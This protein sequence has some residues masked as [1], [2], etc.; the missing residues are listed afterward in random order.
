[1]FYSRGV[2]IM[3]VKD[4]YYLDAVAFGDDYLAHHGIKGQ[5]WGVRRYQN[6]DGSLTE[7]GKKRYMSMND[8]KLYKTLKKEI[9]QRRGAMYGS[10][11][12]WMY[13]NEIGEHSK[14][15]RED[16]RKN[17]KAYQ[18]TEQYK[19]ANRAFEIADRKNVSLVES[20]KISIEEYQHRL[21]Q[22][23]RD[24]KKSLP[25]KNYTN[26]DFAKMYTGHGIKYVDDFVNKG[27][28]ELS[29]ARLRDLGYSTKVADDFVKRMARSGYTLG[30]I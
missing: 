29:V 16:F 17:K 27:G 14:K 6:E 30:D 9:R 13:D 11:N 23:T 26:L 28:A 3:E 21:D 4:I 8:K 20:G 7:A 10:A 18:N 5:K 2:K 1:M 12:R 15:L 25:S 22:L 24:Y 19:K